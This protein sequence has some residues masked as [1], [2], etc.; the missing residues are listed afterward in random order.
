VRRAAVAI[1]NLFK[2]LR[3]ET[4]VSIIYIT[5]DLATA[6]SISD[7]VIIMRRG[8][9]VEAGDARGTLDHPRH[10]YSIELKSALLSPDVGMSST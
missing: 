3:D 5:H 9:V 10:S 6:Y 8:V 7:R 2:T 1:V 4:G